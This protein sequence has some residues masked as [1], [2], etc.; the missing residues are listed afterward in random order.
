LNQEFE[1]K[2]RLIEEEFLEKLEVIQNEIN[3]KKK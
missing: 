2:L 1:E 3:P